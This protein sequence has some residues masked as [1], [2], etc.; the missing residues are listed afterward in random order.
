MNLTVRRYSL[1]IL[2]TFF[3]SLASGAKAAPDEDKAKKLSAK[4]HFHQGKM[5]YN[6]AKYPNAITE[7]EKGYQLHADSVFIY[8]IAQSYRLAG[9][10]EKAIK[11]AEA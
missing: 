8:N 11:D 10:L 6:L 5:F 2:I 9:N 1:F 7:F 4:K 3:V